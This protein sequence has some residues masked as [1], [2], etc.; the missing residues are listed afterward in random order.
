MK[1]WWMIMLMSVSWTLPAAE[2]TTEAPK[3]RPLL[4]DDWLAIQRDGTQ[5]SLQPPRA[6][7]AERELS[8]QRWLESFKYAIPERYYGDSMSVD[9][10]SGGK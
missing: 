5:A 1:A 10:D 9:G 4:T 6:T 8:H 3:E 2:A 7:P